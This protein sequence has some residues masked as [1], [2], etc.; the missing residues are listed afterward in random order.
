MKD[1]GRDSTGTK[2]AELEKHHLGLLMLF[3]PHH[4]TWCHRVLSRHWSPQQPIC[5]EGVDLGLVSYF[6]QEYSQVQL[7][8][9][10]LLAN[11]SKKKT[12]GLS[13][14]EASLS[15]GWRCWIKLLLVW[16]KMLSSAPLSSTWACCGLQ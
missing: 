1:K 3:L 9:P 14:P 16:V 5:L 7:C 2:T 11:E 15:L 8:F 10:K 6:P 13:Y 4:C 12:S